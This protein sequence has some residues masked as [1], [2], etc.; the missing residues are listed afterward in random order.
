[1]SEAASRP[2]LYLDTN[3]F[4]EMFEKRGA[5]SDRLL[6]LFRGPTLPRH[7][8]VTSQLT[9]A[10]ILVDA[11]RDDDMQRND[12]YLGFLRDI[13]NLMTVAPISRDVLIR[14]AL[15]RAR[16]P[17]IKLPDAIHLSTARDEE[18]RILISNDARMRSVPYFD[19]IVP[20]TREA[21]DR[22]LERLA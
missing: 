6:D 19:E 11:I 2:R 21:L 17:R 1:M 5:V 10:E 9:I 4:I 22:L 7:H 18:C 16:Q 14:A 8:L 20:L 3:V 15:I 13:P 12:L